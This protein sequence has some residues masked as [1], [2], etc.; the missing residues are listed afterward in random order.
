MTF[1]QK[2]T[3]ALQCFAGAN[4]QITLDMRTMCGIGHEV[5]TIA[6]GDPVPLWLWHRLNDGRTVR[7]SPFTSAGQLPFLF[8]LWRPAVEFRDKHTVTS[9]ASDAIVSAL[10]P[11]PLPSILIDAGPEVWA[12]WRLPR[13][14]SMAEGLIALRQIGQ[15]LAANV[16]MLQDPWSLTLPLAGPVR[17]W[18]VTDPDQIEILEAN[19]A[20]VLASSLPFLTQ[21]HTTDEPQKDTRQRTGRARGNRKADTA[22][23]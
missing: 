9:E 14:V 6:V 10:A 21:E 13:A 11:M 22:R 3:A 1:T 16:A 7:V 18:N 12:A 2:V 15:H 19:P 5:S 8:A 4:G 20:I 23:A 17:N